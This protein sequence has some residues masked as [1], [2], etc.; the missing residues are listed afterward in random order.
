MATPSQPVGQTVS[1]YRILRK[2]GGGGMGI[3]YEAEDLKLGRHIALK[4][5][6][7]EFAHDPQALSRFQ[8]EAKAA[9]SLNHSNIC[10]IYE[11]DEQNG[12]AFIAME[13][14]D[15]LTL[16]H[17]IAGK[18]METETMLSLGIEIA[19]ALDAAHSASMVHRDIKP[20]NIFATKRGHAKVLDFGLAKLSVRGES[21]DLNAPTIDAEQHLTSPGQAVGNVAYM[22]PEQAR[23]KE[24]DS[25]TD[26]FSFGTVLYE[27]A[28]GTL[29]FRGESSGV[30]SKAI[31]DGTPTPAAGFNPDLP[32]KL[33][34]IISK[35][36]EKDR[37]LRYQHAGE[38]RTDLQRLKRDTESDKS[39]TVDDLAPA[40]SIRRRRWVAG[41][42]A[43]IIAGIAGGSFLLRR[44]SRDKPFA[45][46]FQ[47]ME[48]MMLTDNGKAGTA[49]VSP[50]GHYVAYSLREGKQSTLRL[51]QVV[52]KR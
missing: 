37:S 43:A 40:V 41:V 39:A 42:L 14:L 48:V 8:R 52:M 32:S 7:D 16:K 17:R 31:L 35:C 21:V 38:V 50:D 30:I 12:Q 4:F 13:F 10:T 5:L 44:S 1:H 47:R 6:P 2:I 11:I 27:M 23:C 36:L 19:D 29:P 3:V 25:R 9:S 28:T 26:L 46:T 15:G 22:S 49:S 34:E 18:P 24:L 45:S 33:E 20:A 51:R